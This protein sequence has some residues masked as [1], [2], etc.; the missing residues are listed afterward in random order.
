MVTI[1][2]PLYDQAARILSMDISYNPSLAIPI[3]FIPLCVNLRHIEYKGCEAEELPD[4]IA[5]TYRLTHLII[6]DN[7]LRHLDNLWLQEPRGLIILKMAN[8]QVRSL[9][10]QFCKFLSLR[11]LDMSS[12]QLTEFPAM[13]CQFV[14]LLYLDICFNRITSFPSKIGSL[15]RLER[16]FAAHNQLTGALP[17]SFSNL[18]SLEELDLRHNQLG[19]IDAVANLPVLHS[20]TVSHNRLSSY[21]PSFD[22]L[23]YFNANFNPA[24]RF[25]LSR[26]LPTLQSL[27]LSNA[28]LSLLDESLFENLP[29]LV[30]LVLDR[31]SLIALPPAIAKLRKLRTLSCGNNELSTVPKEIGLLHALRNLDLH[32]NNI[33]IL[34]GEI[35]QMISLRSLNLSSNVLD[36]FPKPAMVLLDRVAILGEAYPSLSH[37]SASSYSPSTPNLRSTGTFKQVEDSGRGE[38]EYAATGHPPYRHQ[39]GNRSNSAHVEDDEKRSVDS[40]HNADGKNITPNAGGE[41][42]SGDCSN[43]AAAKE[44]SAEFSIADHTFAHRLGYL[45][46]ADNN[47]SDE[48][49]E[50]LSLLETLRVL[51]L[52]YNDL[53]EIPPTALSRMIFLRELFLSGNNL[54]ALPAEDLRRITNLTVL[55]VNNN[56]LQTLPAELGKFP[57]FR[58]L[59]AGNNALKY[60]VTNWRYDWNWYE[61]AIFVSNIC[62]YYTP[63]GTATQVS[64]TSVCLGTPASK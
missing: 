45:Y 57:D 44:D 22:R 8:N 38:G 60:N 41:V 10:D 32:Y 42:G 20:F 25:R 43:G 17:P 40:F 39:P 16:L 7:R 35:W 64:I 37:S 12:N 19:N 2:T 50:E 51:N 46:L 5:K 47:L 28:K 52:S 30:K 54:I 9:P 48:C 56:K 34:P 33:K 55:Y 13:L 4:S 58:V 26:A 49:F 3:D 63:I 18:R 23:L 29:N 62:L 24:S 53:Y 14:H 11:T 6:S 21:E 59:D 15:V 27:T 31:N 1:P 36:E 61:M